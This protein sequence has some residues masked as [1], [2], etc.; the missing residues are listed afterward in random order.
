[1]IMDITKKG[2]VMKIESSEVRMSAKSSSHFEMNITSEATFN[3]QVAGLLSVP[4]SKES[5][6]KSIQS[7]FIEQTYEVKH[8]QKLLQ[9]Y[10]EIT[11]V[12]LEQILQRFLQGKKTVS[13]YP[14]ALNLDTSI[15]KEAQES[16]Q[17]VVKKEMKIE[18][19]IT[20]EKKDAI[21]FNTQAIIKT[22][23]KEYNI[24]LEYSYTKAFFEQHKES[25]EFK[26][27]HFLDPLVI[28]YDGN[29]K[30]FD[31]LSDKMSFK[32][33]LNNNETLLDLPLLKKGNGFLVLDKN[34]NGKIDNGSE[35]FGPNT[36]NGFE[37]LR[38]F[39]QDSNNW[40]DDNDEIFK[41]LLIWSKNDNGEDRLIALG[42][43]GIGALYLNEI[44]SNF[45]YNKSVNESMAYL[46]SSSIF[47]KEDGSVGLLSS[48]DFIA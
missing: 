6:I 11:K 42:Q 43:I 41:D 40:I 18:K 45:S 28:Q 21:A 47:L 27:V 3:Q 46:K 4:Q 15:S 9:P 19:T 32:F 16:L 17:F 1:M 14:K 37:E 5:S 33:D 25:L 44:K 35:L 39:D 12:I 23:D 34:G 10:Q 13:F 48:L 2:A 38:E 36:N 24:N 8:A 7:D 30:A 22:N 20:Y 29:A 26:E 31:T